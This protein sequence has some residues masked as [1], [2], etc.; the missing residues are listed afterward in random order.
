[1]E[2]VENFTMDDVLDVITDFPLKPLGRKVIVT[3]NMEEPDNSLVLSNNSLSESQYVIAVGTH[4][5]D[6]K[7][8]NKVLLD[9]ERMMEYTSAEDNAYEKVGRIKIKPIEVNN[10]VYAMINENVV[11]AIDNR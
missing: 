5:H 10:K 9:L 8:G 6:F 11:D 1:M 4:V 2:E 7:P 3:L